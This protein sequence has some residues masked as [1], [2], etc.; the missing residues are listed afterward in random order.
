MF[1]STFYLAC[2]ATLIRMIPLELVQ[3]SDA[4]SKRHLFFSDPVYCGRHS[5]RFGIVGEA[6][7]L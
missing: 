1:L 2:I 3:L 6:G 5:T 7:G 4:V